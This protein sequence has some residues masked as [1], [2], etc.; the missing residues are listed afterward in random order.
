[1]IFLGQPVDDQIAN[2]IVAQ[3]LH[4]E[5]EDPDKDISHLHQLARRLGLRGPGHLRHDAVRQAGRADDLL[6][7][8]HVDGARCCSWAARPASGSRCP[9]RRS[10]STS[11]PAA[12][13]ASPP[14]S[15]STPARS[16]RSGADRR[17]LRPA[18]GQSQQQVH[19]DMDRDRYFSAAEAADYGLIDRVITDR[20]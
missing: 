1:V 16:S 18:H 8:R 20:S 6:R 14:T 17:A 4:L 11:R 5:S 9:T 15:R 13:R 19:D 12:I 3:L 7:H 2:L 10:S